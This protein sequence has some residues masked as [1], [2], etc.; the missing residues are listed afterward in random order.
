M[1]LNDID[2]GQTACIDASIAREILLR[3]INGDPEAFKKISGYFASTTKD[4]QIVEVWFQRSN[5]GDGPAT[6]GYKIFIRVTD[7][8][9]VSHTVENT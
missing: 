9:G 2:I 4:G 7:K 8:N 3:E 5:I 6:D 1:L